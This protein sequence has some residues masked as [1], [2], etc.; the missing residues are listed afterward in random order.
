MLNPT[1]R[2][3]LLLA[4]LIFGSLAVAQ[5]IE[6][7]EVVS[8]QQAWG[9]GIVAI[10]A[11]FASGADYGAVAASHIRTRYAYDL[12]PV[13]FKPTKAA[14]VPFRATFE[15]A[16]SYFVGGEIPEDG[17]F[18]LAPYVHVSFD[19]HAVV[20]VG[21]FAY[22]MGIY[23]FRTADGEETAVEYTFGYLRDAEGGLRIA[24][25][26]SSLPYAPH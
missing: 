26:H 16:F 23:T 17:G 14:A 4:T 11:A 21:D 5:P 25:H 22:A 15:A 1:V 13:A 12:V 3:F 20:S 24:L 7:D 8:A 9:E 6:I 18:A 19:N 2:R 10:G